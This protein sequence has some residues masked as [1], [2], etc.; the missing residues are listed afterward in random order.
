MYWIKRVLWGVLIALWA[1]VR[2]V[3]YGLRMATWIILT[4]LRRPV[5]MMC[6]LMVLGGSVGSI[7]WVLILYFGGAERGI[8]H[9]FWMYA[10]FIGTGFFMT[11]VGGLGAVFYDTLLFKLQPEDRDIIYY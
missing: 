9:P 6:G 8:E 4:M 5:Q 1:M 10:L 7:L 11:I 2:L 3:L